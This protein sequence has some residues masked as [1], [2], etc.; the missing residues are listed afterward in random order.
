M[1]PIIQFSELYHVY[2]LWLMLLCNIPFGSIRVKQF[3]SFD[4]TQVTPF[5][6]THSEKDSQHADQRIYSSANC[7]L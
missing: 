4:R 3:F 2:L 6:S 1:K 7:F 5:L